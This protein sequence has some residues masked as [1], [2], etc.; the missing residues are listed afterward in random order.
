MSQSGA[1]VLPEL[2]SI[3]D[4]AKHFGRTP[5]TLREWERRGY[6]VPV[7]VGR[8]VYYRC[9]DVF[10]LISNGLRQ[11]IFASARRGREGIKP[12]DVPVQS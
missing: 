7:R 12:T 8:S 6:L 2:M 10:A 11:Q 4:V 5:R 9:D 1:L 3:T